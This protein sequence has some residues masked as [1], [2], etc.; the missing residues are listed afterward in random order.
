[1]LKKRQS[2]YNFVGYLDDE[3]RETDD[4]E[5]IGKIDELEKNIKEKNITEVVVALPI[6]EFARL[7]QIILVC[8]RH[9]VRVH[10]IPDYF[11]FISKKFRITMFENFPIITIRDEPLAEAHWRFTKRS[12]DILFSLTVIFCFL[13][14]LI[15]ILALLIKLFSRG[16]MFFTQKR[17]GMRNKV[18]KFYKLRTLNADAA[19]EN[20]SYSPVVIGDA[21]IT[22]IGKI[23]RKLI[24]MNFP[25]FLIFL[26]V[27]CPLLVQDP[28]LFHIMKFI[29]K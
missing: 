12:F 14:W 28:I 13:I 8:N 3:S 15:P 25:S 24:L 27:I 11:R 4:T 5:L 26:K 20:E 22:K 1:M 23:L 21:R 29:L 9:A 10:I 6:K 17:L 7:D 18:F 19:T 16:D 2:G